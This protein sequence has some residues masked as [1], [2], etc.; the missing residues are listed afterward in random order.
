MLAKVV[1]PEPSTLILMGTGI[2]GLAALMARFS[3][4]A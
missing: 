3:R 4:K 1:A 2:L